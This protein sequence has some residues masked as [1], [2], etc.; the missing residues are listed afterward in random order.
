MKRWKILYIL[1]VAI[2]LSA[3]MVGGYFWLFSGL[4]SLNSLSENLYTPSIRI[5]DRSGRLLYESI[6]AQGGRHTVIP[7]EEIRL[8]CARL[9]SPPKTAAFTP[10]QV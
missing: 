3:V 6:P 1:I 2:L 7:F 8:S 4:P 5:V 9:P 10:T